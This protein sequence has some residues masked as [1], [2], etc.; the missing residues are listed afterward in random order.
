MNLAAFDL[1]PPRGGRAGGGRG[2]SSTGLQAAVRDPR[3]SR[4]TLDEIVERRVAFL[5]DYQDA[6]YARALPDARRARA[7]GR[8]DGRRVRRR[9]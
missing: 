5:T 2:S 8:D 4:E 6:A 9:R 7:R 3:T 1:G